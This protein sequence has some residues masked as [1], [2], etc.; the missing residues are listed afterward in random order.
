MTPKRQVGP[1]DIRCQACGRF[2]GK[3]S[4]GTDGEIYLYCHN[5]KQTTAI[6]GKK[7]E[8]LTTDQI[9]ERLTAAR[10]EG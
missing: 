9:Y 4:A 8:G 6:L 2:Q 10:T 3:G 1:P 7:L 5:C